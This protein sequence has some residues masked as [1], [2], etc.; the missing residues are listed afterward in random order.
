[1]SPVEFL[2]MDENLYCCNLQ[3]VFLSVAHRPNSGHLRPYARTR[4]SGLAA[5][6]DV[7]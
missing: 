4:E 2:V 5:R 3:V 7:W 6:A 1:M